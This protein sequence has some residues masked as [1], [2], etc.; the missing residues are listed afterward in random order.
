MKLLYET[1][2]QASL[3]DANNFSRHGNY[4]VY[5][6][7]EP[8]RSNPLDRYQL[9]EYFIRKLFYSFL[10]KYFFVFFSIQNRDQWQI[11]SS[12][13]ITT[14]FHSSGGQSS[15]NQSYHETRE[16]TGKCQT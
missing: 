15:H 4:R 12:K 11:P 8:R 2:N 9:P 14:D 16:H 3:F 6:P 7:L 5:S 1:L 13:Q 10:R